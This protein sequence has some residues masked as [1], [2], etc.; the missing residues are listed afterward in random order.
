MEQRADRV[1]A[2][3]PRLNDT[4]S[5]E[6]DITQTNPMHG[7]RRQHVEKT[8]STNRCETGDAQAVDAVAAASNSVELHFSKKRHAHE[9]VEVSPTDRTVDPSTR[10]DD[11]DATTELHP[12]STRDDFAAGVDFKPGSSADSADAAGSTVNNDTSVHGTSAHGSSIHGTAPGASALD[13]STHDASVGSACAGGAIGASTVDVSTDGGSA[14][15]VVSPGGASTSD[16]S[17]DGG[18]SERVVSPAG[19]SAH[20]SANSAA[21]QIVVSGLGASVQVLQFVN[22]LRSGVRQG[23]QLVAKRIGVCLII[24]SAAH[25][26]TLAIVLGRHQ[27]T[28]CTKMTLALSV[29]AFVL[30]AALAVAYDGMRRRCAVHYCLIVLDAAICGV[31]DLSRGKYVWAAYCGVAWCLILFPIGGWGVHRLLF[32]TQKFDAAMKDKVLHS[33]IIAFA[34]S[35]GIVV[36]VGLGAVATRDYCVYVRLT[37]SHRLTTFRLTTGCPLSREHFPLACVR[38]FHANSLFFSQWDVMSRF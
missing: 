5:G 10:R 15:R 4:E 28:V 19:G 24:C 38:F 27:G 21:S 35:V 20:D 3:Q 34:G 26:L 29:S 1:L 31:S 32:A 25:D 9:N 18:S 14:E 17:T 6:L 37:K 36:G 11:A 8:V 2:M 30:H 16:I 7:P 22:R 13:A 12:V 23:H 33:T